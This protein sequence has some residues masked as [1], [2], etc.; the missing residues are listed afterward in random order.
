MAV[1]YRAENALYRTMAARKHTVERALA[2]WSRLRVVLALRRGRTLSAAGRL[3]GVD[4]TTVA[5]QLSGLER[6]F[7]GLLFERGPEGFT[8]TP[9][10]EAVVAA[11]ER[12]E[13]EVNG[14]LRR[15]DGAA[16]GLTGSVRLTATPYLA[17]SILAPAVGEFL[18]ECP[19]LQ[20][21]LIGDNRNLDLSRREADLAL[22]MARPD[23]PGLVTRRLGE[24]AFACYAAAEDRRSFDAQSFLVYGDESG[25]APLQRYL[26]DLV[27]PERVILRSNTMQALVAATRDRLGC[28][29]LPCFTAECD[30]ALRRVRVPYAMPPLTLWLVYH[31]DLKRSPRVRAAIAFIDKVMAAHREVLVPTDFPFDPFDRR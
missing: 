26:S 12:M 10:G 25:S 30:P 8:A 28:G 2:D 16:T 11:A 7:A 18:R 23:K 14:L 22:R 31:E 17:A 1:D 9:L 4:H 6:D 5:R 15:L 21:E 27:A 3:L 13:D 24:I 19:G 29:L 20:L